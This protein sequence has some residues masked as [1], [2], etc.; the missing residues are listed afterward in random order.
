ME[1]I[2]EVRDGIGLLTLNRPG[3][4]NAISQSMF[5]RDLPETVARVEA[6][7]SIRVLVLT[8]AGG[9]FCSGADVSRMGADAPA[10]HA[11]RDAN[12]RRVLAMMYG[13]INL[14]RPVISAVDGV[15][16]GGGMSLALAADMVLATER[17]RFCAVFGRIGLVP[18]MALAHTLPRL[19]GPR[20]A[21]EMA[22]TAR[23]YNGREAK[24]LGIVRSLHAP[25]R[26]LGDALAL[27]ER[28]THGSAAAFAGA[29]ALI[30]RSLSSGRDEMMDAEAEAQLACRGTE[31]HEEAV[32]RFLHKEPRLYDWDAMERAAAE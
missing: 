20:L 11:G 27:A 22:F 6:D 16:F 32:R 12:L 5:D 8:G 21:K 3:K 19:V 29:K 15:A 1:T 28:L 26:L 9:N 24:E 25:E 31:F 17:A 7:P 30:N 18:D 23:S 4:F 13:L 10:D 2:F 14:D